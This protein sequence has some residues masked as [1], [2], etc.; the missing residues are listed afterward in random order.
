VT[1]ARSIHLDRYVLG[2]AP[3]EE[4]FS[5]RRTPLPPLE[6]GDVLLETLALSVDPY[7]QGSMTGLDNYYVPPFELDAPLHSLGLAQVLESRR[8]GVAAGD[9]VVGDIDWAD[10][11]VVTAATLAGRRVGGGT[12]RQV[13]AGSAHDATH[14]LGVLGTTGITAFFGVV[15]TARPQPR[16]TMVIS[17]AAGGVGTVAG[18]IAKIMGAQV[19]GLAS[20]AEKRRLLLDTLGFDAALDYRSDTL[21]DDV[22]ALLPH[23][24]E[25]Y[26]DNVGGPVSQAVMSTMRRPARVIECGQISSY[27]D[28]DGGWRIDIRPIHEHGL[29]LQSFTPSQFRE[30]EPGAVAQLAHWLDTGRLVGIESRRYG[31]ESVPAAFADLFRGG[32]V[33]KSIV[34]VTQ[35]GRVA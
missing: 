2:M 4:H 16:E 5:F 22:R 34:V 23:G 17:A 30:F 12:L 1:R 24:P 25:I 18:Q 13:P 11:S 6:A 15:G 29:R 33:G 14:Y 8:P 35:D 7:L 3:T 26:F 20:T 32:N 27:L 19:I 10:R 31:L 9:V 21:A 28:V